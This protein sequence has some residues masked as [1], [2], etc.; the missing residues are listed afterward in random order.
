MVIG[1]VVVY[2]IL[3]NRKACFLTNK[4]RMPIEL[5]DEKFEE[6]DKMLVKLVRS[7]I[8]SV[9]IIVWFED[10]LQNRFFFWPK[11]LITQ[12]VV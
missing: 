10:G 8:F 4:H 1:D 9:V 11:F 5:T 7:I 12:F 2:V 6:P 3:L